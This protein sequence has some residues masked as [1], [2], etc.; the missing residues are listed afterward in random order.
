MMGIQIRCFY[1]RADFRKL[2]IHGSS[3][4][5]IALLDLTFIE[6]I[7]VNSRVQMVF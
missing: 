5:K 2:Q 1:L 6:I 4:G 3:V 7:V